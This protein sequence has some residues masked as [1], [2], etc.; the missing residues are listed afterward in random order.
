MAFKRMRRTCPRRLAGP[1]QTPRKSS[2]KTSKALTMGRPRGGRRLGSDVGGVSTAMCVVGGAG[3]NGNR[4][5][6]VSASC[7]SRWE[8]SVRRWT[9]RWF[10]TS[11]MVS[12]TAEK[13]GGE[14]F[15]PMGRVRGMATSRGW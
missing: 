12:V 14:F 13:I 9:R 3:R 11:A 8:G 15:H 10:A 2:T 5:G 7:S 4:S 1:W 6:G